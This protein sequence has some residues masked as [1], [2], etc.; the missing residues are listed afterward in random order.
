MREKQ[1]KK[2][3]FRSCHRLFQVNTSASVSTGEGLQWFIWSYS[4]GALSRPCSLTSFTSNSSDALTFLS[5]PSPLAVSYCIIL[6]RDSHSEPGNTAPVDWHKK[7]V[8]QKWVFTIYSQECS[9]EPP[10]L[11]S[12]F[13]SIWK[14]LELMSEPHNKLLSLIQAG[15]TGQACVFGLLS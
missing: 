13:T 5:I 9:S 10:A 3:H 15:G 11:Q 6:L 2:A 7:I 14:I 12:N 1:K 8:Q 4:V